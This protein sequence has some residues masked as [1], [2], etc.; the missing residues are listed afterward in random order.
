MEREKFA[1]QM[2]LFLLVFAH[3]VTMCPQYWA[4]YSSQTKI[5]LIGRSGV[6]YW[7]YKSAALC[8]L[9][10]LLSVIMMCVMQQNQDKNNDIK[11]VHRIWSTRKICCQLN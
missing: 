10:W 3:T 9:H 11:Y 4:Q 6:M 1:S 2:C 7:E 8:F 5:W